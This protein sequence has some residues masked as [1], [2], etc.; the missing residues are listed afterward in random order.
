MQHQNNLSPSF[1]DS[2]GTVPQ[3]PTV[4][5]SRLVLCGSG[6]SAV[7]A[8]AGSVPWRVSVESLPRTHCQGQPQLLE[9]AAVVCEK[10]GHQVD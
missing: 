2:A 4:Q 3:Q 8:A 10:K 5:A 7:A 9:G 6:D 1:P